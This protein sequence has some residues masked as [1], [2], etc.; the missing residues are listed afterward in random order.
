MDN[1]NNTGSKP[2]T[3]RAPIT[4]YRASW[5]WLSAI[6]HQQSHSYQIYC[7]L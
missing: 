5:Y 4:D 3:H 2:L 1:S 6:R 7:G